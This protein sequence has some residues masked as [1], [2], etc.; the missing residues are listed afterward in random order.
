MLGLAQAQFASGDPSA[1][2]ATL[3]ELIAEN[4]DFNSRTGH[5]LYARSLE[6]EGNLSKAAEEYEALARY[7]A[8]PEATYRQALLLK[9]LGQPEQA[10]Q[11]LRKLVEDAEL[12]TRHARSLQKEWLDLA[13][14]ELSSG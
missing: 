9:R 3:D 13:K 7:A 5:L 2:R 14:K 6:C 8:G 4:P 12:Q 1:S 10:Q 11:L